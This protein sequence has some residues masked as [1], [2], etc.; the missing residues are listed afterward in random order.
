MAKTPPPPTWKIPSLFTFFK[1]K[2]SLTPSCKASQ[3]TKHYKKVERES[4]IV[5]ASCGVLLSLANMRKNA[6]DNIETE[7]RKISQYQAIIERE[8]LKAVAVAKE[9]RDLQR[10]AET[11]EAEAAAMLEDAAKL[12]EEAIRCLIPK[13]AIV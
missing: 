10:R 1:M 6:Q 8:E 9:A 4:P 13:E 12:E 3:F 2:P 5:Q 11:L 7:Q